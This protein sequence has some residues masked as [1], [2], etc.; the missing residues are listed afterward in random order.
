MIKITFTPSMLYQ[1][2]NNVAAASIG[3]MSNVRDGD[4]R[5]ICLNIDQW[6]GQIG[7][8]GLSLWLTNSLQAYFEARAHKNKNPNLGDNGW[9]LLEYPADC[10][11]SNARFKNKPLT[12]YNLIVP[13]R[14]IHTV[15]FILGLVKKQPPN[16]NLYLMGWAT[17]NDV[18][19][20]IS[21]QGSFAGKYYVEANM[22]HN[23]NTCKAAILRLRKKLRFAASQ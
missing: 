15:I 7:E 8:A 18:L 16:I 22:L 13:P 17:K 4:D 2:S 19:R 10:K 23:M 12:S 20:K 3:G 11:A 5:Q 14:E 6:V 1:I 21:S 9:D